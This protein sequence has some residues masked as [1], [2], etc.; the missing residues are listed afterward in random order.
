MAL[1]LLKNSKGV[2][3]NIEANRTI[4]SDA[5]KLDGDLS[6]SPVMCGFLFQ[7]LAMDT[8]TEAFRMVQMV[9]KHLQADYDGMHLEYAIAAALR[10]RSEQPQLFAQM[11]R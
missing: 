5:F 6:M 1:L 9:A 10:V 3:L 7:A 4:L 8:S 2:P 11:A